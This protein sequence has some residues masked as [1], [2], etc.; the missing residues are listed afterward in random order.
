MMKAILKEQM[1]RNV[2]T[3]VDDIVVASK[4]KATQI[5]D[6]AETF[7]NMCRAQLKL[8]PKKC[9]FRVHSGKVLGSLVSVKEIEANPDKINAIVHMNPP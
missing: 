6:I 1:Y 3:Y 7:V 5:D 9:V 2:F 4:K 8:N